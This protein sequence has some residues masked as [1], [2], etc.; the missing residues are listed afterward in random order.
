MRKV[1]FPTFDMPHRIPVEREAAFGANSSATMDAHSNGDGVNKCHF[2]LIKNGLFELCYS[3]CSV[4][5]GRSNENETFGVT[6]G[7]FY[8]V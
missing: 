2:D 3:C 5:F 8:N 1:V 4:S 7:I 6:G